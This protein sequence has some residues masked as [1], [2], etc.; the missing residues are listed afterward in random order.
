MKNPEIEN[1]DAKEWFI[2]IE[3]F[4]E[5]LANVLVILLFFHPATFVHVDHCTWLL[6]Q[7]IQAKINQLP[8]KLCTKIIKQHSTQHKTKQNKNRR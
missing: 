4:C 5:Y 7:L 1:A 3:I 2:V 8:A 6:F